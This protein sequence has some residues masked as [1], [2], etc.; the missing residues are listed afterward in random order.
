MLKKYLGDLFLS[1]RLYTALTV[2]ALLFL[3]RF[4]LDWL[5]VIPYVAAGTVALLVVADYLLLFAG[6]RRLIATR[7][8]AE[9]FSNGDENPV[10]IGIY[11]GY[12][13]P[14]QLEVIDEIPPVFQRRDVL[15]HTR[16]EP[17]KQVTI[18]YSLR[19]VKR[20]A[21][22]FGNINVY[23]LAPLRLVKRRFIFETPATVAVY[24]SYLQMR[25]YQLMAI[26]NRLNEAGVKKLR[27]IGHSMEFEQI[28]EYVGGDDYRTVN[29]KAT[30]RRG[31]L[32]VNHYTDE[33]SQQ[34]Y[35]L[36][37]KGRTMKMPFE[38]L[39][40]LDYAINASL[41]LVNVALMKEDKAG[42]ITFSEKP[43]T[44]LPADR[45]PVQMQLVLEAL[46]N[47]K[48][49]YLESD[50][51]RLYSLIRTRIPQRSLMVLF[52]NFESLSG[53]NRQ[54]TYMRKIAQ[55]HL[56]LVVFFENTGLRQL[57]QEH[58]N[59][60][61]SIYQKTIAEKFAFEKKLI[62]KELQQYGIYS[63]LTA[64]QNLTVNIINK[65]LE[66]KARQLV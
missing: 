14:L 40:L 7:T 17:G 21:Y 62:V 64:P 55:H 45:K 30:A 41:V 47:Q 15:F 4:F 59:D 37:D 56:L 20:G 38:G 12:T 31:Q 11:S 34:V 5:G 44:L 22:D 29:W 3:L 50:Y 46:Y 39:S 57:T 8:H 19:P 2:C 33:K 65:Y 9:R 58:V 35:C 23:A 32:M 66:L 61:E 27:R 54:L 43:G 51:E 63:V 48:S 24:P 18:S 26:H 6:D 60:I 13:V 1:S 10:N 52:T 25:M 28:K 53:L 36:I 42:L 49:R 16:L